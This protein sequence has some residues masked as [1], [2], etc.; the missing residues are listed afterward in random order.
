MKKKL[1]LKAKIKTL[2]TDLN[3]DSLNV[4]FIRCDNAGDSMTIKNEPEIKLFG[5]KFEFSGARTA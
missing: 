2:L 4:R 3:I 5:V 1:D